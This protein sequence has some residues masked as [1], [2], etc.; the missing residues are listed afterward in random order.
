MAQPSHIAGF[1][2]LNDV[3]PYSLLCQ[4]W[5]YYYC[6]HCG[7]TKSGMRAYLGAYLGAPHLPRGPLL[8][9]Q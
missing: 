1:L 3:L 5:I 7:G 6:L 8:L 9:E 2:Y 4:L